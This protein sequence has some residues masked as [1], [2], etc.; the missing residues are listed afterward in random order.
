MSNIKHRLRLLIEGISAKRWQAVF[1]T[2]SLYFWGEAVYRLDYIY[3]LGYRKLD[4]S[5]HYLY[6]SQLRYALLIL[7]RWASQVEAAICA[8]VSIAK[9]FW[10]GIAFMMYGDA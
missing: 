2:A 5:R 6:I 4:N 7:F 9:Q 3:I 8:T 10:A 1:L